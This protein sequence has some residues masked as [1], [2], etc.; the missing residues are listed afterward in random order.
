V[1]G[2]KLPLDLEIIKRGVIAKLR[3]NKSV[4][5]KNY[6]FRRRDTNDDFLDYEA[7]KLSKQIESEWQSRWLHESKGRET[8]SFI[9]NVKFVD[10]NIWFRPCRKVTYLITAYGPIN[11]TLYERGISQEENC[12]KCGVRETVD[13]IIFDYD[14]Y[15]DLRGTWLNVGKDEKFKLINNR[16]TYACF[17]EFARYLF[18]KKKNYEIESVLG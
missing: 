7:R 17:S 18:L 5:W 11:A 13:H 9:N 16:K 15:Q 12:F 2:G 10:E 6:K 14:L 8:Y 1:I 4:A 3:K